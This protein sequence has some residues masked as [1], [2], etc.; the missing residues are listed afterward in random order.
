M[1]FKRV[2]TSYWI[3]ILYYVSAMWRVLLRY[4]AGGRSFISFW[5]LGWVG[6]LIR[7]LNTV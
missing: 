2:F 5:E 4:E 3:K 1:Y 7:Q 6:D